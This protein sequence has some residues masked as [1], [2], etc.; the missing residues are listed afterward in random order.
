MLQGG[1]SGDRLHEASTYGMTVRIDDRKNG[2]TV[3]MVWQKEWYDS[4]NGMTVR[5]VWQ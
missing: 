1:Q 4:K 3:R 2:M 5:M